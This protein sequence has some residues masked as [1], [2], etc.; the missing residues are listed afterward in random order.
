M[1]PDHDYCAPKDLTQ[2]VDLID[3]CVETLTATTCVDECWW[4]KGKEVA[5]NTEVDTA[6]TDL[7]ASNFCHPPST[8]KWDEKAPVCLTMNTQAACSQAN[9][10]WSTGKEL[11][12]ANN[13]FCSASKISL[14]AADFSACAAFDSATCVAPCKWYTVAE[15]NKPLCPGPT[16]DMKP[17]MCGTVA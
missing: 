12:P 1:I 9:C 14:N 10:E 13:D 7:F 3:R 16:A 6:N 4:R 5:K 17:L 11:A 8:E 2:D 15:I